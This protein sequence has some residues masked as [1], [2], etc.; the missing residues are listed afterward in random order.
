MVKFTLDRTFPTGGGA[1]PTTV[2]LSQ[3]RA[4]ERQNHQFHQRNTCWTQL[5]PR[6]PKPD[7]PK[8]DP[9]LRH[10]LDIVK[11]EVASRLAQSLHSAV[12]INLHKEIHPQQVKPLGYEE[13]KIG[14]PPRAPLPPETEIVDVFDQ[15]EMAGKLLILGGPGAGKTTM[16][17]QLAKVLLARA[18]IAVDEPIPVLLNLSSWTDD[19]QPLASWLV[20]ELKVKYGV[21]KDIGQRWLDA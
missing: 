6:L 20:A 2:I 1:I 5:L 12:L 16:L 13:V 14:P 18:E 7:P 21:R 17:L 9:R 10:L 3:W 19:T 4:L 15:E 8:P 11:G